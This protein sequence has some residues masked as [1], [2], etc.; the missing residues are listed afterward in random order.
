MSKALIHY[1]WGID[2]KEIWA[3][4]TGSQTIFTLDIGKTKNPKIVIDAGAVQ[5][6]KK[7]LEFNKTIKSE[8]LSAEFLIITHAHSDHAGMVPY[9]Y[10]KGFSGRIIMTKLTQLQ[11]KEMWL[12]YVR[13]T[14]NEIEKVKEINAKIAKKLHE[15]LQIVEHFKIINDKK[16]SDKKFKNSEK[17]LIKILGIKKFEEAYNESIAIL[18]EYW[19][20]CENDIWSVLNEV[21]ELLF[22][23]DDIDEV[24]AKIETLELHEEMEL[25]NFHPISSGKDEK[26]LQLPEMVK[27]GYNKPIPVMSLLI[28]TVTSKLQSQIKKISKESKENEQIQSENEGLSEKIKFALSF[29]KLYEEQWVNLSNF[30]KEY[31]ELLSEDNEKLIHKIQELSQIDFQGKKYNI[32]DL[33]QIYKNFSFKF[34][35]SKDDYDEILSEL[36]SLWIETES[37]IYKHLWELP[38]KEYETKDIKSA[39]KQALYSHWWKTYLQKYAVSIH[40]MNDFSPKEILGFL[41]DKKRVFIAENIYEKIISKIHK[42][43]IENEEN[44]KRNAE[45]Q[46]SL[47]NAFDMIQMYEWD[48][49]LYLKNYKKEYKKAQSFLVN[50]KRESILESIYSIDE[51]DN[52]IDI[53]YNILPKDKTIIHIKKLNDSRLYDILISQNKNIVYYFEPKIRSRIKEK[54]S[55]YIAKIEVKKILAQK[56]HEIYKKYINF[57]KVYE[58]GEKVNITSEE[59]NHAKSF[60]AKHNITN[61]EDIKNYNFFN[62]DIP[63]TQKDLESSIA[64]IQR[65]NEYFSL[66]DDIEFIYID[67]LDDERIYDLPYNYTHNN[68]IIVIKE[69]FKEEIRKKLSQWI[70]NS[71]RIS[72]QRRKKRNELN[73]KL[74][75]ATFYKEKYEFLF[76]LEW[77]ENARDFYNALIGRNLQI[78]K[79]TEKLNKIYFALELK[80]KLTTGTREQESEYI[81]AKKLLTQYNIHDVSDIGKVLKVPYLLPYSIEDVKKAISLL[82]SVHIDRNQDIL[83]SIKLNF[84]DAWHIEWSVQVVL[85]TVV[86]AVNNI[87]NGWVKNQKNIHTGRQR[88]IHHINYWFSWDLWRIKDPNLAGSPET[89]PFKLDYYQTESTYA[90]RN[91]LDK[92][93]SI[94]RLFSSIESSAW[95]ILIPAF[96]MQRTQELLMILLEQRLV[97]QKNIDQLK[98]VETEKLHYETEW[99]ILLTNSNPTEIK[100]KKSEL[101]KRIQNLEARIN[102]LKTQIFDIDIVLDSPL[103]EKITKI[104]IENCW[105]K[106]NLLDKEVQIK[107][108]WKEIITYIKQSNSNTEDIDDGRISFDDLY[109]WERRDKKEII[110]S[111]SWMWDGWAIV[112]HLK[113]NLQ[114]SKS[115]IIWVWYCPPNTRWWKIKSGDDFISIEGEPYELKCE[116]D[117]IP[118]FSWHID[119]EELIGFLNE[120]EFTKWALI[121]FTHGDKKR[122]LLSKKVQSTLDEIWK[123]V[124]T[125]VP[126]LWDTFIIKI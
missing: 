55:E 54:L 96:S 59:Y 19:V 3:N 101:T 1:I 122:F 40:H 5:W 83:E 41:K 120:M 84:F 30:E 20:E 4:L 82:K 116:V 71:F 26:I 95:K 50:Y 53:N 45:L 119:E 13:L 73:D 97:S 58:G 105:K 89:I 109:D 63:Y 39:L 69:E 21:P 65:V 32:V 115:K 75:L 11:S 12:D 57:I 8:V 2:D 86:S 31:S 10:K 112:S 77:Y 35:E 99:V 48:R 49:E 87:L 29:I 88:K 100:E 121:A 44:I 17:Y 79:I 34:P 23:T 117:D 60:L 27:N 56:N 114:N 51:L 15:A 93:I 76:D 25:Q 74:K 7:A 22:T 16:S 38:E 123:K 68:K 37:D 85:T 46:E 113:E 91:H 61:K 14:E 107:L 90:G 118:W 67:S 124:K 66:E 94:N 52:I 106:Y 72:N 80:K 28:W 92:E 70:W 18:K 126:K 42:F 104:Y 24:Y 64:M 78:R 33:I 47:Y 110:F 6:V 125:V 111:A 102:Y 36:E 43:I 108:F 81:E 98:E 62:V 9:L 103:S